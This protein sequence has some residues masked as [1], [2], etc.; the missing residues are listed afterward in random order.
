M[1]TQRTFRVSLGN[2]SYDVLLGAYGTTELAGLLEPHLTGQKT[3]L[4]TDPVVARVWGGN[5]VQA[6][7]QM[8]L[9]VRQVLV[10]RSAGEAKT[11]D[12]LLR[13]IDTL[14]AS[15]A[16]RASRIVA[17]GGG[18]VGDVSALAAALFMRGM[19]ILQVPTTIVSAVDSAIGGKCA[20]HYAGRVNLL[21][22]YYQPTLA[23]ANTTFFQTLDVAS[24]RSGLGEIAK[25]ALALRP[26]LIRRIPAVQ[27]PE[28]LRN[29]DECMAI[30]IEAKCDLVSRDE[31]ERGPRLFLNYGHTVGQA[32]EEV[33]RF[34][35]SHGEAVAI[36]MVAACKIGVSVGL[37]SSDVL[38]THID[39]LTRIGLP[40]SIEPRRFNGTP[41]A[42]LEQQLLGAV[43]HDKKRSGGVPRFVLLKALGDPTVVS[44]VPEA[45]IVTGI[46]Q[47]LGRLVLT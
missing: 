27:Q 42:D 29:L 31:R 40:T 28:A 6:M 12:G 44:D 14:V 22:Q 7:S 4:V 33:S 26:E 43:L 23:I 21:G 45:S 11:L 15:N 34:S 18:G 35:Y 24:V 47:I 2:R 1:T 41:P 20:I 39:L 17:L 46:R 37:T 30:A 8:R 19:P 13:V 25:I 5:L 38:D 3:F 9:D 10:A 16:D 32:V 36:G